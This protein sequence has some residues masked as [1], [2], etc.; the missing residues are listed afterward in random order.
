MESEGV[1]YHISCYRKGLRFCIRSTEISNLMLYEETQDWNGKKL[2][3]T[4]HA[5]GRVSGLEWEGFGYHISCNRKGL[6]FGIRNILISH[7]M[8]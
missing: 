5:I 3:I 1:G 8:V 7:L 6:R 2:D 4:S